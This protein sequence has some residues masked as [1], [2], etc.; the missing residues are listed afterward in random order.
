MRIQ[1]NISEINDG[2]YRLYADVVVVATRVCSLFTF[3]PAFA[4]KMRLYKL[5]LVFSSL[6]LVKGQFLSNVYKFAKE[7]TV[8]RLGECCEPSYI[9]NEIPSE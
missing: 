3:R 1:G 7:N 9:K 2:F 6:I 4:K 5:V 8:C